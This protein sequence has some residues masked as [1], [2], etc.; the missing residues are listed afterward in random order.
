[1]KQIKQSILGLLACLLL[2]NVSVAAQSPVKHLQKMAD[3]MIQELE[4]NKSQLQQHP[5]IV[6]N[7]VNQYFLP[8]VDVYGMSRSVVGRNAWRRAT[9][10]QRRR[11]VK[12]FTRLVINTYAGSLRHYEDEKIKF[13][14]LRRDY[15][16]LRFVQVKSEIVRH[17]ESNIPMDY[18]MVLKGAQWKIYDMSIEGVSLLQ[19]FRSQFAAELASGSFESLIQRLADKNQG[20]A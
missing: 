14:P 20:R 15:K 5:Q 18:S 4:R 10:A 16:N 9:T 1:M 2:I 6:Y 3:T 19:S 13:F 17:Q 8:Y 7:I 12:Q 11:F